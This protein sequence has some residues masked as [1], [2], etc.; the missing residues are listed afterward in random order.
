M[1]LSREKKPDLHNLSTDALSE[2][3]L[4]LRDTE[5]VLRSVYAPSKVIFSKLG[6]SAGLACHFHVV[7]VTEKLLA[8]IA[9]HPHYA[10]EPDGNDT[11]LFVSRIYCEREL[12]SQEEDEMARTVSILRRAASLL[13]NTDGREHSHARRSAQR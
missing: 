9:S 6:F 4:V 8:E 1:V 3:G 12:A 7:P 2:L 5:A 10:A 11:M 13:L